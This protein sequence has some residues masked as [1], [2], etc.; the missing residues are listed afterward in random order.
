MA[1]VLL[2]TADTRRTTGQSSGIS[3][4]V[5]LWRSCGCTDECP[6][7]MILAKLARE[8]IVWVGGGERGTEWVNGTGMNDTDTSAKASQGKANGNSRTV[9]FHV[10]LENDRIA[11]KIGQKAA[12]VT[13]DRAVPAG[14]KRRRISIPRCYA[15]R[16]SGQPVM[17]GRGHPSSL[18]SNPPGGPVLE[19][20]GERSCDV[21]P[22]DE[23]WRP[24]EP[25]KH[26][27]ERWQVHSAQNDGIETLQ[28]LANATAVT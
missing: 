8:E 13:P 10:L 20:S 16:S 14:G 18:L 25:V 23:S 15:R 17:P 4:T 7:S 11:G 19:G 22:R 3:A 5:R 6:T 1:R 28:L 21:S 2:D 24:T 12:S 27:S 9:E 26:Q